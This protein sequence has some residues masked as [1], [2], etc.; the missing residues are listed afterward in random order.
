[1][2][3][4]F[5]KEMMRTLMQEMHAVKDDGSIDHK[6]RLLALKEARALIQVL[7]PKLNSDELKQFN[8]ALLEEFKERAK[9]Y[10]EL[11]KIIYGGGDEVI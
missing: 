5:A 3:D 11:E 6:T 8:K 10:E 7:L 2:I 4:E 9:K 1:M